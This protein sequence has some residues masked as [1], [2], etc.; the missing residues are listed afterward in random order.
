MAKL[1]ERLGTGQRTVLEWA[2][3]AGRWLRGLLRRQASEARAGR[4]QLLLTDEELLATAE[5]V[6]EHPWMGGKKGAANLVHDRAAWIGAG[7]YDLLK[8]TLAS[9]VGQEV[10]GRRQHVRPSTPFEMPRADGLNEVWG[11]DLLQVVAWGYRFDVCVFVDVFNQESLVVEPAL[12]AADGEFV[13]ECFERACEVRGGRPPTVC[14]KTDRGSQYREV[15]RQAL[16]GRTN[17]VRIPPGTPWFNGETE[18]MNRDVRAV[19]YEHVSRMERPARGTELDGFQR[20]CDA[21]RK[22]LNED[23]SRPSLGN[24]TP[25]EVAKGMTEEVRRGNE[26]FIAEQRGERKRRSPGATPWRERLCKLLGLEQWSTSE[27]LRFLR[28]MKRDYRAWAV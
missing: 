9:L 1:T 28:L 17:H 15:F 21:T 11:S 10:A 23:I 19:I 20:A 14:T 7:S 5:Q 27:L 4:E 3:E 13:A 25:A 18:R 8:G 16:G 24:V 2:G 12:H 22:V 6:I 26:Q